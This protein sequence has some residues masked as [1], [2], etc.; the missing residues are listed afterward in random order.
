M[1]KEYIKSKVIEISDNFIS[2]NCLIYEEKRIFEVRNFDKDIF[3]EMNLKLN[4]FVDIEMINDHG[5]LQLNF[6]SGSDNYSELFKENIL[7]LEPITSQFEK[8]KRNSTIEELIQHLK[9]RHQTLL[10][11]GWSK[12]EVY[13]GEYQLRGLRYETDEELEIRKTKHCGHDNDNF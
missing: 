8:I 2:L 12:I 4:D 10:N 1:N 7:I 13:Y 6:N 11:D 9:N 3:K 5:Y